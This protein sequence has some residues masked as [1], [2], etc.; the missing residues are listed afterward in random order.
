MRSLALSVC[1][2]LSAVSAFGQETRYRLE[3]VI[4]EGS[5]IDV[6]IIRGETR[7]VEEQSYTEE[8]FRQAVYRVRRLP[9]VTDAVYRIEPGVT[10]GGTTLV[11]RILDETP[12]FYGLNVGTSRLGDGDTETTGDALL[13]GRWLLDNLGVLEGGIQKSEGE[14]GFLVG[15]G[16]RAYNIYGTGGFASLTIAQ[17]FQ[18]A[19]RR[20]D[21]AAV[22]ELGYPLT[23]TQTVKLVASRVKSRLPRDF[24]VE[25]D[26]DDDDEDDDSDEDD[27]V[28]LTE[29]DRFEFAEL[30]WWYETIDD[31]IFTTRGLQ[32]SAG[33]R[34]STL[35]HVTETYDFGDEE[36]VAAETSSSALGFGLDASGFRPFT[37]RNSV[38]LD[39]GADYSRTDEDTDLEFLNGAARVGVTHDFLSYADNVLRPFR[40]RIEIGAG[41][42]GSSFRPA[43]GDE[44]RD[45]RPF[46]EA[47][48]VMR[49]RWGTVRLSA[50]YD[51]E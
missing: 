42:R 48:F 5:N 13:G 36:V 43:T 1:L 26:D 45:T 14:D 2:L 28:T 35:E 33:P 51:A 9:F 50:F 47:A 11:I 23:Q 16:Y 10:G 24:D 18:A 32:V 4:V 6:D 29:R 20:Y 40:A 38:F 39:L 46:G 22:L 25:G 49:H 7:L 8:D 44:V 30:R 12:I 37:R 21:P 3:R 34:W 19:P 17:R 15:L 27:N 41:Y 31:P